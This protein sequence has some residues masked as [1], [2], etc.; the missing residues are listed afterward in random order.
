[1]STT[2]KLADIEAT[3]RD[4]ADMADRVSYDMRSTLTEQSIAVGRESAFSEAA[5][6]VADYAADRIDVETPSL[7]VVTDVETITA[8]GAGPVL[9]P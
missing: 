8:I 4:Y 9:A 3:L 7:T 1:M 2:D 6:L 5:D